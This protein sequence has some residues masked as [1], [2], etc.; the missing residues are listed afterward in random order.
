MSRWPDE[1]ELV[2]RLRRWLA[3]TRSEGDRVAD[4]GRLRDF[5]PPLADFDWLEVLAEFTALRHEVKLH[6]KSVRG[7]EDETSRALAGLEKAIAEFRSVQAREAEAGERTGRPLVEAIVELHEAI[8]RGAGAVQAAAKR[9]EEAREETAR[10]Y[11]QR[12]GRLP[13]WQRWL[14]RW[15]VRRAVL[16]ATLDIWQ[17]HL[18]NHVVPVLQAL[19]EGYFLGGLRIQRIMQE[20]KISRIETVGRPF[21]PNQ[22]TAVE[23]A[24]AADVPPG[25]VAA[26]IRPGYRWHDK[27]VRFAE[28]RVARESAQAARPAEP[29]IAEQG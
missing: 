28:V 26:E 20:G 7:L 14:A 15:W 27:V 24:D 12:L 6:T 3:E 5:S 22:M 13:W 16:D 11:A 18:K 1:E 21:D 17:A 29:A 19:A 23:L 9:F 2:G 4:N 25:H 8:E 10:Q